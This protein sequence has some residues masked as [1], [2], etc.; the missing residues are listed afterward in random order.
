MNNL[1]KEK[2]ELFDNQTY[3]M[4]VIQKIQYRYRV[5]NFLQDLCKYINDKT[6]ITEKDARQFIASFTMLKFDILN[7]NETRDLQLYYAIKDMHYSFVINTGSNIQIFLK[8]FKRY[9][10]IFKEWKAYDEKVLLDKSCTQQ[11]KQ[12]EE[13]EK[14][15]TGDTADEKQLS[16]SATNLK[17]K[18]SKRIKQ[19]SGEKGLK[20]VNSSPQLNPLEV[21][22]LDMEETM[23]KVYWDMFEEDITKNKLE[24]IMKVLLDFQK[25]FYELIGDGVNARKVKKEFETNLDYELIDQMIKKNAMKTEDIY[26]IINTIITYV[27]KYIQSSSEDKDTEIF[28]ENVGKMMSN[29][30]Q[31][32]KLLRYFFQNIFRKLDTTKIQIQLL[33]QNLAKTK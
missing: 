13:M 2:K 3:D 6:L 5:C 9:L 7:L 4:K 17:K 25:Y 1:I 12:L 33:K 20:Y 22:S 10:N 16:Q 29:E 15:F 28:L 21:M 11:Y 24:V 23:K 8:M 32:G 14:K 30:Y 19:I 27:K 31:L 26:G 18:I